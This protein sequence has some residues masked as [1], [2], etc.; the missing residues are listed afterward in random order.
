MTKSTLVFSADK[1][2]FVWQ[3]GNPEEKYPGG[4][5]LPLFLYHL[6]DL[7]QKEKLSWCD[8][9]T[10]HEYAVKEA[11]HENSLG[12]KHLEKISLLTLFQAA[13]INN[14]SDAIVALA[15]HVFE[16][17][18]KSRRKIIPVI[19]KIGGRWGIPQ[20]AIKNVSGRFYEE[21]PQ[22]FTPMMLH[23]VARQLLSFDLKN[24]ISQKNMS[25]KNKYF[26]SDSV[27]DSVSGI[28]Y[29]SFSDG[30]AINTICA[31]EYGDETLFIS[32]CGAESALERDQML[33]EALHRARVSLPEPH[34]DFIKT[35]KAVLTL[36]GDTYCGERYTKW[37]MVRNIED[38]MQK[39]GDEGYIYSFKK[40]QPLISE[41]TFNIVNSECVLS[42][43][44]EE[45]Q[46][47]GKYIDFV[48]G[49]NPEKTIACYKEI[50]IDAVMLAN[51]HAMDFGAVGCR[52]TRRYF[53][54][55]GLNPVGTG[56][57]I[58]EAE[59]PLLLDMN[60]KQVIIFNAYCFYLEKR[61]KIFKHYCFGINSGTAFGTD[62]LDDVS[63]WRR[64]ASY[65]EKYPESFIVFSP[66]WSTDFNE[67]HV[68]LRPIAKKAFDAGA[69][70]ILGHGPHIPIGAEH[71][72][73]KLCVYSLGNF[74]FN[75]TGIDLDASGKS[76]Y[77]IVSQIDF[78]SSKPLLKLYPIYAH[79]LNTF[80]QPY[81]VTDITQYEEFTA[82]L[83]GLKKFK[84][85][86]D[87]IGYYLSAD[88]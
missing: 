47:T 18:Y 55:A 11:H 61:H 51:N 62:I 49:A 77:G 45:S 17:F 15:R 65:R 78:S 8:E 7:I 50:N 88:L 27:L 48:L 26:E 38:P 67:R 9:V 40:V 56:K 24:F 10:V 5:G 71:I 6:I 68:H 66:H 35:G 79:S 41:N 85:Q 81:P 21:N 31:Y 28:R 13:V 33:L 30:A 69:D 84:I 58:D 60:G 22:Y 32:A 44:Y 37:R 54:Q 19:R 63:L 64:I 80:F 53:E 16:K 82:P 4:L 1:N 75:T 83:I 57:N 20:S 2:E 59:K 12:L 34:V 43:V 72:G 70:I 14:S 74:V 36:C 73:G 86:N 39:Y 46:Q 42:P 25:F 76:P 3:K 52:Q 87:A 29:F 23:K